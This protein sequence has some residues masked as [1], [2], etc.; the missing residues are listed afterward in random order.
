MSTEN[1]T[2][3]RYRILVFA[4]WHFRKKPAAEDRNGGRINNCELRIR[5]ENNAKSY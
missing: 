5:I 3:L 1:K 2:D 4:A